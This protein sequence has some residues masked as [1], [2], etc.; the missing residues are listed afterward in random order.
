MHINAIPCIERQD[1]KRH[2]SKHQ[3][4]DTL[5]IHH[6]FPS[7]SYTVLP[8]RA[9]YNPIRPLRHRRQNFPLHRIHPRSRGMGVDEEREDVIEDEDEVEEEGEDVGN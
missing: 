6:L 5:F 9:L 4:T 1:P 7:T 2:E 8:S 3:N